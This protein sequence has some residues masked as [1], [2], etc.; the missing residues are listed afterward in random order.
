MFLRI[1]GYIHVIRQRKK[2]LK[3]RIVDGV[4]S[5]QILEVTRAGTTD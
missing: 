2:R 5:Q 1:K 3:G 4:V